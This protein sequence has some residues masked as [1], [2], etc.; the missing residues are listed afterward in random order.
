MFSLVQRSHRV[1]F[2]VRFE[3]ALDA[4]LRD[5]GVGRYFLVSGPGG[6]ARFRQAA[7]GVVETRCAGAF[8]EAVS[9]VPQAIAA[10]AAAEVRESGAEGVV[11]FGGGAALDTAKAACLAAA[12][13]IL[14]IPTNFSGS[15]VTPNFGLTVEGFKRGVVD[16]TILP[17]TVIYDP[18][19]SATLPQAAAVCSGVNAIAHALEALYAREANPLTAATAEAGVRRMVA[20]L[21][22][23]GE[24]VRG[25]ADADCLAGAWLCGEA[26]AQVGMALHHRIC[27]VLGGAFGLPH[28]ETHTVVLPYSIAFN[29]PQAPGLAPLG[30]LFE[31]PSLAAGL[32]AFAARLGA[33]RTLRELGLQRGDID[34]A[35]RLA[36]STALQNPRAAGVA[37]VA[38]IITQAFDGA[39]LA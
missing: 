11:A 33:P 14:A 21:S 26:L 10:R 35:A 37:D 6:A 24:A 5:L 17:K 4:E 19:L 36:L 29:A 34:A 7:Q 15:E 28:A 38:A 22:A 23:R 13:P 12:V 1:V 16:P 18:R 9:H 20:G 8:T 32:A 31:G 3:A 2:G 30:D 25:K 39:A 27:H